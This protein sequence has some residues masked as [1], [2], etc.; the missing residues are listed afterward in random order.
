MS[1]TGPKQSIDRTT[2][3]WVGRVGEGRK[4]QGPPDPLTTLRS[5]RTQRQ[6]EKIAGNEERGNSVASGASHHHS[7]SR[8]RAVPVCDPVVIVSSM[9]KG[10][11]SSRDSDTHSSEDWS[12][13]KFTIY[14][15]FLRQKCS[16]KN[17]VFSDIS[18]PVILYRELL[19]RGH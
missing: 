4:T 18:L 16:P 10:R 17:L 9:D 11:A 14:L 1:V 8:S 19:H 6:F 7:P 15:N 5:L 2:S 3:C 13:N 12:S